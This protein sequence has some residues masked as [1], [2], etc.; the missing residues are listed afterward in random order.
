MPR[1]RAEAARSL[2]IETARYRLEKKRADKALLEQEWAEAETH[3]TRAIAVDAH[4]PVLYSSRSFA[5]L[6]QMKEARALQDARKVTELEP[7]SGI[8][9]YRQGRA[10]SF[11]QNYLEAG[12]L[13]LQSCEVAP[14]GLAAEGRFHDVR[15]ERRTPC[16]SEAP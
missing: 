16:L 7:L 14:N 12:H 15:G 10:L 6:R 2:E 9:Y 5:C 1:R 4:N 8:G 11:Q 13:F 3:L